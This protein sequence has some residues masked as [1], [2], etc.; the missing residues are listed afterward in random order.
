[1]S[2]P[3]VL[4]EFLISLP[5]D[6]AIKVSDFL[7]DDTESVSIMIACLEDPVEYED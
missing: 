3:T 2:I 1:M 5:V 4:K 7:Y 6:E